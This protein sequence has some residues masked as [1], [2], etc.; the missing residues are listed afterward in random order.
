M[1]TFLLL[2]GHLALGL[3]SWLVALVF[4][5]AAKIAY[6][7]R[8]EPDRS[9][10]GVSVLPGWP[11]IPVALFIPV[12]LAGPCHLASTVIG[13]LNLCLLLWSG[14]YTVYF[15]RRARLPN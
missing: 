11:T 10:P 7:A 2:A 8:H 5:P 6:D 13:A 15:L 12:V 9:V 3:L 14:A 1:R 4:S